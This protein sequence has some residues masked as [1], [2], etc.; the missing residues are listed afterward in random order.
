MSILT[1]SK[2]AARE[3]V[4][5]SLKIY[6][7]CVKIPASTDFTNSRSEETNSLLIIRAPV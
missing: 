6:E 5:G 2:S 3:G 4:T 7:A 1:P